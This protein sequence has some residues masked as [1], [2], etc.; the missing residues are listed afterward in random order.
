MNAVRPA[1]ADCYAAYA[2]PGLAMVNVVIGRNGKVSR[3]FV[4]GRFAGTPTGAC[5]EA[6]VKTAVFPP[7]DG[8]ST[9]YPFMLK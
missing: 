2:V 4:T 5:V 9:P 8:L 1:V 7:S 6:A 3:A